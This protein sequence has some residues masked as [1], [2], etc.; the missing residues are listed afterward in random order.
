[1]GQGKGGGKGQG[2]VKR[3]GRCYKAGRHGNNHQVGL[4]NTQAGGTGQQAGNT[5]M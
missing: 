2:G 4:G 5:K 1:M 3:H